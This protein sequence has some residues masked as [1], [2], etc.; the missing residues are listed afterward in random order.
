MTFKALFHSLFFFLFC[1]TRQWTSSQTT[2]ACWIHFQYIV[3]AKTSSFNFDGYNSV[4]PLNEDNKII[5]RY[6][7][8]ERKSEEE[9]ED[10]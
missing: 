1:W 6:V 5:L 2:A 3:N 10:R 7:S 4:K 8:A 9:E